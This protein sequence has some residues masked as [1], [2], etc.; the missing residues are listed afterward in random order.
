[1]KTRRH[2]RIVIVDGYSTGRELVR[3]LLDRNV[4][5]IHLCSAKEPPAK[6]ARSFDPSPYDADLGYVG[7]EADAIDMIAPLKVDAVVAGSEYGV[8]FAEAVA[9][10]LGLATNRI[11]TL[12]A[13]RNKF[14][15]IEAVRRAG[16]RAAEQAEVWSTDGAHSWAKR[17]GRWP[18]VVKPLNSAGSD[19]VTVCRSHA[20]IERACAKAL[21]K[22]NFLGWY[23]ESLLMQSYLAGEQYIVNTVSDGGRHHVTDAWH[24]ALAG[25]PGSQLAMEALHLLDPSEPH[26][27]A[28]IDYTL[29]VLDALGIENGAAHTELKLTP[30]GPVVIESGARLMG[31]AMDQPSYCRA[32]MTTQAGIY[33]AVLAGS[34]AEREAIFAT[35]HYGFVRPLSKVFFLFEGEGEVQTTAGLARLSDLPS[36]H[37][38]YRPIRKGARV[39]KTDDSLACGGAM[40]LVHDDA[41]RIADDIGQIRAWEQQGLLYG[42]KPDAEQED[43]PKRDPGEFLEAAQ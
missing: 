34:A 15:M 19:G 20:D 27:R 38:L 32:E 11:E 4:E 25:R 21:H 18:V 33:A 3:K 36:F 9:H 37:A 42:V 16:L 13:R 40:Y 10:G 5:C 12:A 17:H 8:S 30:E 22:E 2:K 28:L 29:Q 35:P 23:N 39:W 7:G 14:E 43:L 41:G 1:M 26:V 31:A 24:M 6:L